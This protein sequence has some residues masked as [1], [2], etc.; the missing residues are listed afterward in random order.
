VSLLFLSLSCEHICVHA[1]THSQ[2]EKIKKG[3]PIDVPSLIHVHARC[4][5]LHVDMCEVISCASVIIRSLAMESIE[6]RSIAVWVYE[7][8]S[9]V[10]SAE[11]YGTCT[12]DSTGQG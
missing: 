10:L 1:H 7:P 3:E 12:A 6:W 5:T 11:F 8:P 4:C 9:M 2:R